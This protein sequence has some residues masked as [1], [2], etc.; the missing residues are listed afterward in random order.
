MSSRGG[1]QFPSAIDNDFQWENLYIKEFGGCTYP[2]AALGAFD[3]SVNAT[4]LTHS[5]R[6]HKSVRPTSWQQLY[7][8]RARYPLL[9]FHQ[10]LC[11][12]EFALC[13]IAALLQ[14]VMDEHWYTLFE[15]G[16]VQIAVAVKMAMMGVP[17]SV[18]AQFAS[19]HGSTVA[20]TPRS[21]RAVSGRHSNWAV[22][23][24]AM[25]SKATSLRKKGNSNAS[26]DFEAL[27]VNSN[28][29]SVAHRTEDDD[30]HSPTQEAD[31]SGRTR[32]SQSSMIGDSS[33]RARVHFP[34]AN[35][36]SP[37]KSELADDAERRQSKPF[38]DMA[39]SG[40]K[41][42][43]I[44]P[45]RATTPQS[46]SA[47]DA[48]SLETQVA[49]HM[50]RAAAATAYGKL[51]STVQ[52]LVIFFE[53]QT[54]RT[55]EMLSY[56]IEAHLE[57]TSV[58][59]QSFGH[60]AT[61]F[62]PPPSSSAGV[63]HGG[64]AAAAPAPPPLS[65]EDTAPRLEEP[66][67][68]LLPFEIFRSYAAL[69]G[70]AAAKDALT[71]LLELM[72]DGDVVLYEEH[73][74]LERQRQSVASESL[75]PVLDHRGETVV[76]PHKSKT[77]KTAVQAARIAAGLSNQKSR[78]QLEARISRDIR[79]TF[80]LFTDLL[81]GNERANPTEDEDR[82]EPSSDDAMKVGSWLPAGIRYLA[83]VV[84]ACTNRRVMATVTHGAAP[85]NA[86]G[87]ASKVPPQRSGRGATLFSQLTF[88]LSDLF[89]S[90][91]GIQ[92]P[93]V[94]E[95]MASRVPRLLLLNLFLVRLFADPVR[96]DM[97]PAAVAPLP[98]TH[99]KARHFL[100]NCA[101][102]AHYLH[103]AAASGAIDKFYLVSLDLPPDPA[104]AQMPAVVRA[105]MSPPVDHRPLLPH[106]V[107]A[108]SFL[109]EHRD[110]GSL[111]VMPSAFSVHLQRQLK[112]HTQ[113]TAAFE[114]S[115]QR[116][117]DGSNSA[118][119]IVDAT[120]QF[121]EN[122]MNSSLLSVQDSVSGMSPW[123]RQLMGD[124]SAVDPGSAPFLYFLLEH[125]SF[126]S[127][128]MMLHIAPPPGDDPHFP[129]MGAP[130]SFGASHA[131]GSPNSPSPEQSPSTEATQQARR[132]TDAQRRLSLR[133]KSV[134]VARASLANDEAAASFTENQ[135]MPDFGSAGDDVGHNLKHLLVTEYVVPHDVA[136]A[137]LQTLLT[138]VKDREVAFSSALRMHLAGWLQPTPQEPQPPQSK[139]FS[140]SARR[141]TG[142]RESAFAWPSRDAA[143]AVPSDHAEKLARLMQRASDVLHEADPMTQRRFSSNASRSI[144]RAGGQTAATPRRK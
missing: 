72:C 39:A 9:P 48:S 118:L 104:A 128:A 20:P 61:M 89:K 23:K 81:V 113:D 131:I 29:P 37:R 79:R 2:P 68:L 125:W 15:E 102:F 105:A 136:A 98:S 5:Q 14:V 95:I 73:R 99:A 21:A 129:D 82:A 67:P 17:S 65:A 141:S 97:L 90:F 10:F 115:I 63:A 54:T 58:S 75:S 25:P 144:Q 139:R 38:T 103:T 132:S 53:A 28:L 117:K 47:P 31:S 94:G 83:S 36:G 127:A 62:P 49:V 120:E 121:T 18:S 11:D 55:V 80:A 119:P 86:R 84:T 19:R 7:L 138:V 52:D 32:A 24:N 22:A 60:M 110:A 122:V 116:W 130:V 109:G 135:R 91:D 44:S 41:M 142:R 33:S 101:A 69:H 16:P 126:S 26:L 107:T 45:P 124:F 140:S 92:S 66:H 123:Q 78:E 50:R 51:S 59:E 77:L 13:Q 64:V 30:D 12:E 100:R 96:F 56:A 93:V 1:T 87:P 134:S 71:P 35:D 133:R 85:R 114:V 3:A 106:T 74:G 43:S 70:P 88:S 112:A 34:D 108:L 111:A 42:G 76:Q 4:Q 143:A 137:A 40:R 8:L 6:Q 57:V 46:Q 27:S